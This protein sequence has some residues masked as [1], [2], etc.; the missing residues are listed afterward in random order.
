MCLALFCIG[1]QLYMDWTRKIPRLTCIYLEHCCCLP[2]VCVWCVVALHCEGRQ[3]TLKHI[4]HRRNER[5]ASNK[6]EETSSGL[7]E[8]QG[9]LME[10]FWR[11]PNPALGDK[12]NKKCTRHWILS[13]C[14]WAAKICMHCV[15][16]Y[17]K[18]KKKSCKKKGIWIEKTNWT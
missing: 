18:E 1:N 12:K 14:A 7:S 2:C 15:Y 10:C 8:D 13:S 5:G 17:V 6:R 3:K 4:C 16:F 9:W 11:F